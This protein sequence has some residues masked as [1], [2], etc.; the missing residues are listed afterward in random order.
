LSSRYILDLRLPSRPDG[1]YVVAQ[2]ELTYEPGSGRRET[3]GWVPL[4]VSYT[5]AGHGYVNAEVMKHIDDIQLKEM[6]DQ[7]EQALQ[8]ND[9]QAARRAAREIQKKSTV[10]GPR[11]ARKTMLATQALQELNDRGRVSKKTQLALGD[12]ARLA[13]M[14]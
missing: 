10:M 6:S 4:E 2:L 1:K 11:A 8:N 12:A 9:P 5:A 13:E 7:L 14:P 3:S